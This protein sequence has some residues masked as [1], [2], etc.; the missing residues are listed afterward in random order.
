M[1]PREGNVSDLVERLRDAQAARVLTDPW[2]ATL[3]EEAAAELARLRERERAAEQQL[4]W[5]AAWCER[6][7][8]VITNEVIGRAGHPNKLVECVA[9]AADAEL[10]RLRAEREAQAQRVE[11]GCPG[12]CIVA[13]SCAWRRHTQVPGYRISTIGD[14]YTSDGKRETLGADPDSYFETMVFT[15]G[16]QQY[17]GNEGCGCAEVTNW[18]EVDGQRYATAGEAQAGHEAMVRKYAARKGSEG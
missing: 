1:T 7:F 4:V 3:M 9:E 11:L 17:A 10:A 2:A 14:Y 16:E 8:G 18:S 15:I 12:H 6:S 13:R 5:I